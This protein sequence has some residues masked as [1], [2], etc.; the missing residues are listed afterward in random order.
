[1]RGRRRRWLVAAGV[2]VALVV[3]WVPS[4]VAQRYS[5]AARPTDFLARPDKGWQFLYHSVR[6]SR[7][8]KLGSEPAAEQEASDVWAGPPAKA[9]SVRLVYVE[10]PFTVPV[11][12]GGTPPAPG[13]RV[14]RPRSP[15]AWVVTGSV[16]DGPPQM[17][18]LLDYPTGRASWDIR[19]LPT[20]A[21]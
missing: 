20:E 18:G 8:A 16:R 10:G 6:L 19:P 15:L 2:V 21:R 9:S 4:F 3:L 1:M 11:P 17:I 13:R 14:A 12:P 7:N 5:L